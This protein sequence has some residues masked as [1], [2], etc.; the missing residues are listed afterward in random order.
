MKYPDDIGSGALTFIPDLIKIVIAI[1]YL[2]RK[3]HRNSDIVVIT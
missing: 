2:T 1:R 3:I